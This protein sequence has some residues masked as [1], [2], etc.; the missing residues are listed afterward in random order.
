MSYKVT[1][2][3]LEGAHEI[4]ALVRCWGAEIGRYIEAVLGTNDTVLIFVGRA[5]LR[6]ECFSEPVGGANEGCFGIDVLNVVLNSTYFER[7]FEPQ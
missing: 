3:G 6:G 5:R 1:P 7:A 2:N 4:W